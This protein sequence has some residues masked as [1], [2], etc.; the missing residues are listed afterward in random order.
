MNTR[1]GSAGQRLPGS[2]NVMA[3]ATGQGSDYWPPNIARYDLHCVEIAV[4]R[5]GESGL[6]HVDTQAIELLRQPQFLCP[7]HAATRGLLSIAK[8]GVEYH[9]ALTG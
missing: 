2:F 8:G 4:G 9:Y 3:A 5:D 6:N 7:S 1:A